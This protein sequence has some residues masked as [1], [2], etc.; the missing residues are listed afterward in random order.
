MIISHISIRNFRSLDDCLLEPKDLTLLVGRND[1]GKSNLLRALNLFFNN[2]TEPGKAFL[3]TRDYCAFAPER[4]NK[5]KEIVVKLTFTPPNHYKDAKPISWRK[6]WRIGGLHSSEV[7]FAEGGSLPSRGKLATWLNSLIFKYVPAV[8]SQAYFQQLLGDLHDTLTATIEKEIK[9]AGTQ[10]IDKIRDN[11]AQITAATVQRLGI[12]SIIGLP[13]DLKGLFTTLDF[14]TG[15]S[16][17]A[18][19][20]DARGDGIKSRHIP[21]ILNFLAE[22]ANKNKSKGAVKVSTIWGYEEPENNLE[23]MAAFAL[24]E[25]FL[26]YA[27]TIQLLATTH[28]PA[29]YALAGRENARGYLVK[30]ADN[31]CSQIVPLDNTREVDQH[32]G[33]L[34]LITPYIQEHVERATAAAASLIQAQERIEHLERPDKPTLFLE[35]VTDQTVLNHY[36]PLVPDGIPDI[37]LR[38]ERSGGYNWVADMLL[39][40]A[41]S[42]KP[43]QAGGLLDADRDA[44]TCKERVR[45]DSKFDTQQ[46]NRRVKLFDYTKPPHILS[47]YQA[48]FKLPYALEELFPPA[49]WDYAEQQDWLQERPNWRDI[50]P[51]TNAFD[52]SP[53][54]QC[55]ERGLSENQ[56]RYIRCCVKLED[57]AKFARYVT[58]LPATDADHLYFLQHT[59][60]PLARALNAFFVPPV[61]DQP[62]MPEADALPAD[63]NN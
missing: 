58:N 12:Q 42:R 10:F 63:I 54:D 56:V 18:F 59:A 21:I 41:Y 30:T 14:Q 11:T 62:P 28:S 16:E 32:M 22:Q 6:V 40:W 57:K 13:S 3:F 1:A 29:F 45:K 15:T 37:E 23:L 31:N 39:A 4:V 27:Q 53:L 8:K 52:K 35:G 36:L 50:V 9:D 43:Q 60:T 55:L 19:S 44:V 2:E 34:P 25:E 61:V 49:I 38:T 24:A 7:A 20:L 17:A 5:A 46:Q 51:A 33:M 48:G 26:E 47:I